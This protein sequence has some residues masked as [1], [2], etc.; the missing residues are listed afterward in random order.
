MNTAAAQEAAPRVFLPYS[1]LEYCATSPAAQCAVAQITADDLSALNTVINSAIA[2]TP[3]KVEGW[4]AFPA[5]RAGDC[6][7]YVL[8]KR[9]ALLA[10]GLPA[11]AMTIVHGRA[12]RDGKVF[13]HLVLEVRLAGKLWILDNLVADAIYPPA[14]RPYGWVETARQDPTHV[15]WAVAK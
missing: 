15:L 10:L 4:T 11:S 7:D 13:P 6:D 8:T 1:W 12:T 5:S 2:P 9:A 3:D 14:N